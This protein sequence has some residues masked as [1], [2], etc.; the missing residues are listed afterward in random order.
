MKSNSEIR[1]KNL[2]RAYNLLPAG[3][4]KE[5]REQIMDELGVSA[6]STFYSKMKG[7]HVSPAEFEAIE[8]LLAVHNIDAVTG[9]YIRKP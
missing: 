8:Q 6:L 5:V 4:Q 2:W 1:G 3:K 7:K 9:D